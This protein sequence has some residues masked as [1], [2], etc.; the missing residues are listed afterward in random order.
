MWITSY[1]F[2]AGSAREGGVA[3]VLEG[4]LGLVDRFRK[5]GEGVT[6]ATVR[7]DASRERVREPVERHVVQD[8][9]KRWV[10]VCPL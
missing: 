4:G 8:F 9:V 6:H 10:V 7:I 1:D 2:A 3:D 5:P